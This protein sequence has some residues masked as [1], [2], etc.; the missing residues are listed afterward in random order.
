MKAHEYVRLEN[1]RTRQDIGRHWHNMERDI[2]D[3]Q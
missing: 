1:E 2:N 3:E